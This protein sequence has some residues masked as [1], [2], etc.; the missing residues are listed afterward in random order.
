MMKKF[1]CCSFA[2]ASKIFAVIG[3]ISYALSFV[4]FIHI[5]IIKERFGVESIIF[6]IAQ[7]V[8]SGIGLI[9]C[10]LPF[11]GFV[12]PLLIFTPVDFINGIVFIIMVGYVLALCSI[13]TSSDE[14]NQLIFFQ[15]YSLSTDPDPA[16]DLI[17]GI[18]RLIFFQLYS[19]STDPD[20]APALIG[21]ILRLILRIPV[22]LCFK[23]Y[24]DE[25]K[26][27]VDGNQVEMGKV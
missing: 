22:W 26:E 20:P 23:S 13:T 9:C 19:L 24:R 17:G 7:C 4:A 27:G 25:L 2:T 14:N 3:I 10:I 18:L 11:C 15:L 6:E 1:C 21:G 8:F 16:P 12:M 5:C